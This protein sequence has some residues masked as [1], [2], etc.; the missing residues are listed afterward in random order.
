MAARMRMAHW[1]GI[2]VIAVLLGAAV[3]QAFRLSVDRGQRAEQLALVEQLSALLPITGA[4]DTNTKL[5]KAPESLGPSAVRVLRAYQ[6]GRPIGLVMLI[7]DVPGYGG[8][9]HAAV[10]INYDGRLTGVEV[11]LHGETP[12][13][14]DV[15][16]Q[17]RGDWP[18]VFAG[19]SLNDPPSE[20]WKLAS[21]GG[22]F[23]GVAG[24]TITLHALI[25]AVRGALEYYAQNREF[26]Y[27]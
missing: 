2:A 14:G 20:A 4:A 22:S 23:D 1:L 5:I 3:D 27:R 25:A 26:L 13:F 21:E 24:A 10:G 7:A 16:D 19:K 11:L 18:Q 8:E 12:G 6:H 15:I 9:I 17:Q